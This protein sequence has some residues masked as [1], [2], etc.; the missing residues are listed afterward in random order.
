M[1]RHYYSGSQMSIEAGSASDNSPGTSNT[2]GT[3]P[4]H[5][6]YEIIRLFSEGLYQSPHKAVE[7]LV[8]NGYDAGADHVHVLLPEEPEKDGAPLD[9]L[10]VIDNGHGMDTEPPRDWCEPPRVWWRL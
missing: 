6:S 1:I 9:A 5:I 10:W 2:I 3:I 7:E 4:V 8:S